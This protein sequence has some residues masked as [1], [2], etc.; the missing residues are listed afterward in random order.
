MEASASVPMKRAVVVGSGPAGS[1][2]AVYLSLRGML[3]DVYDLRSDP[4]KE[5][6]VAG[7]SINLALSARGLAALRKVGLEYLGHELGI[8]MHGRIVHEGESVEFQQY[9]VRKESHLLSISRQQLNERLITAGEKSSAVTYH[10]RHKCTNLDVP[11]NT[12]TFFDA[13]TNKEVTVTNADL[14]IGADGAFSAVRGKVQ[15][16]TRFDFSQ[17]YLDH[18][19]KELTLPPAQDGSFQLSSDGLHIWPRH[20]FMLIG[21]PNLDRTFTVTLFMP[22]KMF[23]ALKTKEDVEGF[24]TKHFPDALRLMPNIGDQFFAN[25]TAPLVWVK[26]RPLHKSNVVII[27]DAAHAV[28]PFY[29]QGMNCALE[30]V[31]ILDEIIFDQFGG[32]IKKALKEFTIRRKPDVDAIS[33]LSQRNYVEMRDSV[34]HA[35]YKFRKKID[36]WFNSYNSNWLPQYDLVS[37]TTVPYSQ[38]IERVAYQDRFIERLRYLLPGTVIGALAL[39]YVFFPTAWKNLFSSFNPRGRL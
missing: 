37:F 30:D 6:V 24:F 39:S 8:P 22:W 15:R 12:I 20:D 16:A 18:A 3:V 26:C 10:W 5:E 25:P 13:N 1:L 32:D 36:S 2:A 11:K 29:G 27:G 23:K 17:N 28:V 34:T 33:D 4:R 35:D 14:I 7:K 21:L 38:V 31:R 19:Y 9:G